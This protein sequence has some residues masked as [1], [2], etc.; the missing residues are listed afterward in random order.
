MNQQLQDHWKNLIQPLFKDA[1]S[2][3]VRLF[4]GINDKFEMEMSWIINTDQPRPKKFLKTLLIIFPW[5]MILEYEGKAEGW[6]KSADGKIIKFI[7]NNLENFDPRN[8]EPP[9]VKLIV[10]KEILYK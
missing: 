1:D 2:F 6:Q 7:K 9:I 5:E 4:V 8:V 10:P 3:E